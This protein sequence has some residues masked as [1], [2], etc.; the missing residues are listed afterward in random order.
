M[1]LHGRNGHQEWNIEASPTMGGR[2][3]GATQ[4]GGTE[5]GELGIDVGTSSELLPRYRGFFLEIANI[6]QEPNERPEDLYQR[7]TAAVEDNLLTTVGDITHHGEAV[8][9]NEEMSSATRKTSEHFASATTVNIPRHT[10]RPPPAFNFNEPQQRVSPVCSVRQ[11][12]DRPLS[13]S[14][15]LPSRQR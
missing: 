12:C 1:A 8:T 11:I 4:N 5:S 15:P 6:K 14:R 9:T 7:L 10:A 3:R 2:P 13:Q